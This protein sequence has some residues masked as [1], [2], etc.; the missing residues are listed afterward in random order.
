[1]ADYSA[2]RRQYG[3]QGG[4]AH[5]V[6]RRLAAGWRRLRRSLGPFMMAPNYKSA[7]QGGLN[8]VKCR[9][10]GGF[11]R[12]RPP[13]IPAINRPPALRRPCLSA[14]IIIPPLRAVFPPP[15]RHKCRPRGG[16]PPFGRNYS[17][18]GAESMAAIMAAALTFG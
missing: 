15:G 17:G 11:T 5:Y 3:R 13:E 16:N 6:C 8:F 1:M 9:P 2:R 18:G 14:G 4:A 7:A 10:A 12:R